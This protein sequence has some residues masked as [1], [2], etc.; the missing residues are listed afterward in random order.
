[1][2]DLKSAVLSAMDLWTFLFIEYNF[3]CPPPDTGKKKKQNE[4][5]ISKKVVI[6]RVLGR[7]G[8]YHKLRN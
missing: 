2:R 6:S 7:C 3:L 5:N 1:M 4:R 8:F